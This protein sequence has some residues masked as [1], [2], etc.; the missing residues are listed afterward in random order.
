MTCRLEGGGLLQ[1]DTSTQF[2][3]ADDEAAA[4]VL[5]SLRAGLAS[6]E[7]QARLRSTLAAWAGATPSPEQGP[8]VPQPLTAL[9]PRARVRRSLASDLYRVQRQG[10]IQCMTVCQAAERGGPAWLFLRLSSTG[11]HEGRGPM[12]WRRQDGSG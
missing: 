12:V 5:A 7:R 1:T 11:F 10:R 2:A 8:F 4:A 3:D 6:E 9:L